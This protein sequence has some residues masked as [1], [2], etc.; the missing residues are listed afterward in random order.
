MYQFSWG[1]VEVCSM[2][3]VESI[4]L[5]QSQ[6]RHFLGSAINDS[7][8]TA[9]GLQVSWFDNA[10]EVARC[11]KLSAEFL[12]PA[13]KERVLSAS[14]GLQKEYWQFAGQ[15]GKTDFGSKSDADLAQTFEKLCGLMERLMSSFQVTQPEFLDTPL[16]NLKRAI[17][18]NSSLELEE[19]FAQL[20]TYTRLDAI[21]EEEIAFHEMVKAG[22]SEKAAEAHISKFPWL[23]LNTYKL[24][25]GIGFLQERAKDGG[26]GKLAEKLLS[27][28][29]ALLQKQK[30]LLASIGSKEAEYLAFLFQDL[31]FNRIA[32]KTCWA[33]AVW[34]CLPLYKQIAKRKGE[35]LKDLVEVYRK[36]EIMA[37]LLEGK[38]VERQE[39]ARRRKHYLFQYSHPE[40]KFYSGDEAAA[41]SK[42]LGVAQK[43]ENLQ[44]ITGMCASPGKA[45]GRVRI[46]VTAG[47]ADYSRE[48]AEF[49]QGEVLVTGMTQ[50]TM[51]PICRKAA[52]IVTNEGGIT[53]HAAI[54]SRELG[55]PCVVGTHVATRELSDGDFVEVD[56]SKGVVKKLK[57]A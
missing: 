13:F 23:M 44:T 42:K 16:F 28:K 17:S 7:A 36:H 19:A 10:L 30:V 51:V 3:V 1:G 26:D 55:I 37:L 24:A 2:P 43:R 54:I 34:L 35:I 53:S 45:T 9:N 29:E 5:G 27:E 33:S 56:A 32:E 48:L 22:F 57:H 8:V 49:K 20:T 15:V 14:R 52:A 31:G 39:I 18:K 4:V 11:E 46:I 47:L 40:V 21:N 12:Q 6:K 50:I 25:D 38:H 41:L